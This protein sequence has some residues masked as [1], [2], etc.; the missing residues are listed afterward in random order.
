MC[1]VLRCTPTR[2]VTPPRTGGRAAQG[3]DEVPPPGMNYATVEKRR[4]KGRV[5]AIVTR[6]V[7]GTMAAVLC[8]GLSRRSAGRSTRRSWSGRTGRTA[9]ATPGRSQDLRF[10]KDWRY[11]EAVTYLSLYSYN[12][13]WPV[14]TLAAM[15]ERA[16]GRDGVRR[17]RRGWPITS[18]RCPSGCHSPPCG[19]AESPRV[20]ERRGVLMGSLSALRIADNADR[21][22]MPT[23]QMRQ[24]PPAATQSSPADPAAPKPPSMPNDSEVGAGHLMSSSHPA[25]RG[26]Q[27]DV[28]ALTRRLVGHRGDD[29][30][31]PADRLVPPSGAQPEASGWRAWGS[32]AEHADDGSA[33][34]FR[35]SGGH[36]RRRVGFAADTKRLAEIAE[37]AAA[38]APDAMPEEEAVR[39]LFRR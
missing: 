31:A 2:E 6:V 35:L 15:D 4:E 26:H 1:R 24:Q 30:V 9:I 8:V 23:G 27:F 18:G 20:V 21:G 17:W 13:C 11:H 37:R 19:T 22:G 32:C 5:V 33:Q 10:S 25:S 34:T 29:G 12:F 3:P 7:F 38:V 39:L 16:A 28:R 36:H 14:R